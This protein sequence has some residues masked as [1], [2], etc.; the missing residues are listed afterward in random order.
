[1]TPEEYIKAYTRSCSNELVG[2]GYHEWL[3]PEEALRAVEIAREGQTDLHKDFDVAVYTQA[4]GFVN[5]TTQ[6]NYKD[7]INTKSYV[8]HKFPFGTFRKLIDKCNKNMNWRTNTP[9]EDVIVAKLTADFCGGKARYAILYLGT[10]EVLGGSCVCYMED[11]E[12]IPYSAIEKWAS[13]EEDEING[14]LE[15]KDVSDLI[16][17]LS[18]RYPEVS[19]AKLARIVVATIKWQKSQDQQTIELA[20]EHAMLAGMMQE[21]ERMMK[22]AIECEVHCAEVEGVE[23]DTLQICSDGITLNS[24]DYKDGDKVKVIII[25]S[26]EI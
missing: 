11:G 13:L 9:T 17:K 14:D 16:D 1:M 12:E 4:S 19:F 7:C 18:K 20:E 23:L 24:D 5:P 15:S 25:P 6:N 8:Q 21:H 26:E 3:T 10:Q 2:G 22:D